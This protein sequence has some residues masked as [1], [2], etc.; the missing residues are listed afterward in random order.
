MTTDDITDRELMLNR[1]RKLLS[2]V[3]HGVSSRHSFQ[4][5]EM[6]ILLDLETCDVFP[7]HRVKVLRQ[8]EKAVERQ[9]NEGSGPPMKLS[10]FLK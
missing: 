2:E 7:R 1:F 9:L 4:P 8:Y 3:I 5:W 10:D 6:D